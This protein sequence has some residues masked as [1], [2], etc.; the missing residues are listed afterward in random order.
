MVKIERLLRERKKLWPI[1]DCTSNTQPF[2]KPMQ[3]Q[4]DR[5]LL[6]NSTERKLPKISK[7]YSENFFFCECEIGRQTGLEYFPARGFSNFSLVNFL[8][9]KSEDFLYKTLPILCARTHRYLYC[10]LWNV[11][12]VQVS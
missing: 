11:F 5:F 2:Q 1:E 10:P 12:N 3:I 7:N 9:I 8:P 4:Y 6:A